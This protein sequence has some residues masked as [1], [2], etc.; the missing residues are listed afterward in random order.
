[1]VCALIHDLIPLIQ[2]E[3]YLDS[4]PRYK[5]FYLQTLE[6]V[7]KYDLFLANSNNTKKEILEYICQRE[8]SVYSIDGASEPYFKFDDTRDEIENIVS[9][10]YI[11]YTGGADP[12]KN[13]SRLISA[14]SQLPDVLRKEY[15]LVLAGSLSPGELNVLKEYC[16]Q[17]RI[18]Q[19]QVVFAG[20]VTDRALRQLYSHCSLFVFPSYHEGLGL[21]VLEA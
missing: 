14:Y 21:P 11:L 12:R 9:G 4:N 16:V 7:K 8:D 1:P 15:G 2:K 20:Y 18:P 13:L 17:A 10:K 19:D 5:E 3:D 6:R